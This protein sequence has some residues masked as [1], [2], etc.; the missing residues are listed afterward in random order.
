MQLIDDKYSR[1]WCRIKSKQL[2]KVPGFSLCVFTESKDANDETDKLS[3]L[4]RVVGDDD[5]LDS[6]MNDKETYTFVVFVGLQV[7]NRVFSGQNGENDEE[8]EQEM[9]DDAEKLLKFL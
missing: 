2:D 3:E 8:K 6:A 4:V 9:F 1:N 5:F 7:W